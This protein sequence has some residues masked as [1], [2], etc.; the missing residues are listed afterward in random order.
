[1]KLLGRVSRRANRLTP[2]PGGGGAEGAPLRTLVLSSSEEEQAAAR[3][4]P[5]R[6]STTARTVAERARDADRLA[7]PMVLPSPDCD[8][9]Q[10]SR[11]PSTAP[12][13]P[14]VS[15]RHPR[16]EEPEPGLF[17]DCQSDTVRARR[18]RGECYR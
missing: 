12:S 16:L 11:R 8:W 1:M 14:A 10:T 9:F 18:A 2:S 6:T 17:Q 3:M 4:P 5:K 7:M 15:V 13:M